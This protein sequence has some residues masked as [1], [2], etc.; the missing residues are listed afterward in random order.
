MVNKMDKTEIVRQSTR[1]ED[2]ADNIAR[3]KAFRQSGTNYLSTSQQIMVGLALC[4]TDLLAA[5]NFSPSNI[6]QA[7]NRLDDTQREAVVIWFKS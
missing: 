2:V 4:R 1:D 3:I 5:A 6:E 7:W